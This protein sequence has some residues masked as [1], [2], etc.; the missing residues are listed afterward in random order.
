[1]TD[2]LDQREISEHS[3][4]YWIPRHIRNAEPGDEDLLTEIRGMESF[5]KPL[6]DELATDSLELEVV[7][8]LQ[9]GSVSWKSYK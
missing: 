6:F 2:F 7:D 8:W 4:L 1:M 5:P 9:V 3:Y